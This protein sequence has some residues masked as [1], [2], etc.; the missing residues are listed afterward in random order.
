MQKFYFKPNINYIKIHGLP[1]TGLNHVAKL[2]SDN[3]VDTECLTNVGGCQYGHYF[4][5]CCLGQEVDVVLVVKNPYAWLVSI[6]NYLKPQMSFANFVKRPL[7]LKD[8]DEP[9]SLLRAAN[10]VDYWNNMNFHWINIKVKNKKLYVLPHE[11]IVDSADSV[12]QN[13]SNCFNIKLKQNK[14]GN[15]FSNSS[16]Y[17]NKKYLDHFNNEIFN[18]VNQQLEP[19]IMQHVGFRWENK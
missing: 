4:A 16:Y 19:S 8:R 3:L 13:M 10:P 12:L 11:L 18:L 6:Y 1:R 5:P 9:F 7:I 15:E 17:K 14:T 2:L